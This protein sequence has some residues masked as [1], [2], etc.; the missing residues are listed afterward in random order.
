MDEH[1]LANA[2]DFLLWADH[3]AA[4]AA[5]VLDDDRDPNNPV[6]VDADTWGE[7][8]GR[9]DDFEGFLDHDH[10]MDY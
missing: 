6:D 3:H 2:L 8:Y 4:Q 5:D 1:F 7:I 9:M 10:S